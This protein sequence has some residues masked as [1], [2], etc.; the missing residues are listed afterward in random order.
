MGIQFRPL[1]IIGREDPLTGTR[2]EL[3]SVAK[4][5][6]KLLTTKV[7]GG[8]K[9]YKPSVSPALLNC[10]EYRPGVRFYVAAIR[11]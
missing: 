10:N 8:I 5:H 6:C 9:V 1:I 11:K 7:N 4:L 2:Y 3:D